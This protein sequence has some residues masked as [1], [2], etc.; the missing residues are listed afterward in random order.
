MAVASI[1]SEGTA[2]FEFAAGGLALLESCSLVPH[3]NSGTAARKVIARNAKTD[4]RSR[5]E[6]IPGV[7]DMSL[8]NFCSFLDWTGGGDAGSK[9]PQNAKTAVRAQVAYAS[10][11]NRKTL[12]R[13]R[14]RGRP[15]HNCP[16]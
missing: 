3:Q 2:G 5:C 4:R 15:G 1:G 10:P 14:K 16:L 7:E 13:Q 9:H 12:L 8:P 11:G 6:L